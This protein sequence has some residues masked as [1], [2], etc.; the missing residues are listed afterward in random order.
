MPPKTRVD[1]HRRKQQAKKED[2]PRKTT[3]KVRVG[4][5]AS[6]PVAGAI[7]LGLHLEREKD[8]RSLHGKAER[9]ADKSESNET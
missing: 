7:D 1:R 6:N 2:R 8:T 5:R 4:I 3:T 9:D